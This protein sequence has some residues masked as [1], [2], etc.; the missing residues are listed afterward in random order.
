MTFLLF[1]F[2]ALVLT[3]KVLGILSEDEKEQEEIYPFFRLVL[4]KNA[5]TIPLLVQKHCG[6][7]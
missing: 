1:I 7:R 4:N 2:V 5:I 6:Y 3:C